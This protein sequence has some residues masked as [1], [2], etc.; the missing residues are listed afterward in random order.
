MLLNN[1]SC[2]IPGEYLK[3]PDAFLNQP[4]EQHDSVCFCWDAAGLADGI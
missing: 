2:P 4:E 1:S 3:N